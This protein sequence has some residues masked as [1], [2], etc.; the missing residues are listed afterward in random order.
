[1]WSIEQHLLLSLFEVRAIKL[2]R[3]LQ[4]CN[5]H[6]RHN[7]CNKNYRHVYNRRSLY[8][9]CL[10]RCWLSNRHD[11]DAIDPN[12]KVR[13]LC[14]SYIPHR[15]MSCRHTHNY[16]LTPIWYNQSVGVCRSPIWY[17]RYIR[18]S[19]NVAYIIY[20]NLHKSVTS[21]KTHKQDRVSHKYINKNI[22][23][24]IF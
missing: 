15:Y 6:W 5:R 9:S 22:C 11:P 12:N 23:F 18:V 7:R 24:R 20:V 2:L 3:F 21:T 17:D 8:K 14:N 19:H 4:M 16:W 10:C 1:M 13:E